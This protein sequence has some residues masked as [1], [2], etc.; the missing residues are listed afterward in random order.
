SQTIAAGTSSLTVVV[1]GLTSDG[2]SHTATISL[3][4]CST[5]TADYTAPASCSVAPPMCALSAT[6]TAGICASAT[7]TYSANVVVNLTNASSGMLSVS[8]PGAD[9]VSQT[10]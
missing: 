4:G 2:A 1:P 8:I 6:A 3:P 10:V 9:P 5:T 7:N